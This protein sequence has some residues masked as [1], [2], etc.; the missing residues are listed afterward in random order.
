VGLV[1][2]GLIV[3]RFG[4]P[5]IF[6]ASA[7]MAA[8]SFLFVLLLVPRDS[9]AMRA[10]RLNIGSGLLFVPA[11]VVLLVYISNIG[12]SGWLSG[13]QAVLLFLGVGLLGAWWNL[14]LRERNPLLDVRLLRDRTVA[15][16]NLIF[17]L[18]GLGAM[19]LV[20]I[21]SALL[22]APEWTGIGLGASSTTAGLVKLPS[23]LLSLIAAPFAGWIVGRRGGRAAMLAGIGTALAGW[24]LALFMHAS[25][26]QVGAALIIASFG[27]TMAYAAA[28]S[29]IVASV[30]EERS[31]EATGMLMVVR[32]AAMAVGAQVMAL[33][34]SLELV[35]HGSASYPGPR[36]TLGAMGWAAGL[37]LIAGGVALFLVRKSWG[38]QVRTRVAGMDGA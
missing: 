21:F 18:L 10:K 31:G 25:I 24:A 11:V 6:I 13:E 14:S 9:P 15:L 36:A 30:P 16:T 8:I 12:R 1:I 23:N 27:T 19:Q 33:I 32:S 26:W 38:Q 17:A 28:P 4:W 29:L 35:H 7:V 5:A 20:L 37:I 2:G 34:L 3:D 22:Q